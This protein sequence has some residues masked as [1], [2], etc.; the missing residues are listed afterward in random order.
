VEVNGVS[1]S[2]FTSLFGL[3]RQNGIF[4]RDFRAS[5]LDRDID[6][7]MRDT[8]PGI[9]STRAGD[10]DA[11]SDIDSASAEDLLERMA[12]EA[13]GF[14]QTTENPRIVR[15]RDL[16]TR[17]G[18]AMKAVQEGRAGRRE[19][20]ELKSVRLGLSQEFQSYPAELQR[21]IRPAYNRVQAAL[22]RVITQ[23][24]NKIERGTAEGEEGELEG[25]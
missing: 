7:G 1:P 15:L 12:V 25:Q 11:E 8:T 6:I 13:E 23:L 20:S 21:E 10:L 2:A 3:A 19:L 16:F 9:R 18:R 24:Q 17:G 14:L 5:E 22:G 4:S